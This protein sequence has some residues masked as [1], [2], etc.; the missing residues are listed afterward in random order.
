[1]PLDPTALIREPSL[2]LVAQSELLGPVPVR[3]L[4]ESVSGERLLEF[5]ARFRARAESN[6]ADRSTRETVQQLVAQSADDLL[7]HLSLT[8]LVEG[9]SRRAVSAL[10]AADRGISL[11]VIPA[12][13]LDEGSVRF[14][15][16]PAVLGDDALEQAW[17]EQMLDAW[18]NYEA[19]AE[20]L[21]RRF[22]WMDSKVQRRRHARDAAASLL[23]DGVEAKAIATASVAAWRALII[24]FG[25]ADGDFELR[26]LAVGL[27]RILADAVPTAFD[28][29]R[30]YQAGDRFVAL[31][32]RERDTAGAAPA[33]RPL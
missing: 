24:R 7:A 14:V 6:Q 26:R 11:S 29:V 15:V 13:L 21:M 23:P 32:A 5:V 12:R 30:T 27:W 4:G 25:E 28:D 20:A 10:S 33:S 16:P 31:R 9:A 8:V 17:L 22:A 2:T 3:A 18:G 1:M 19:L